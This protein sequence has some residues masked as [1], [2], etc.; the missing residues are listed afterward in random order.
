MPTNKQNTYN[1]A[2]GLNTNHFTYYNR[3]IL[4]LC[5][6]FFWS[7]VVISKNIN[8]DYN[9]P[10]QIGLDSGV[11]PIETSTFILHT[12]VPRSTKAKIQFVP[13]NLTSHN[14]GAFATCTVTDH[15]SKKKSRDMKISL[16]AFSY[17][18]F[19]VW[20]NCFSLHFYF[21]SS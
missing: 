7:I 10:F 4:S 16:N 17:R 3:K 13:Q 15:D 5:Q 1:T 14:K 12:L 2:A 9:G 18:N 6:H 20:R 21:Q 19:G 11:L 8:V